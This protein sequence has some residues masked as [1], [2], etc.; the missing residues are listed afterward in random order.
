[1]TLR[2]GIDYTAAAWQGAGIG[3]YTRELVRAIVAQGGPY[4]YTLF[5]AA[6]GIDRASPYL[7]EL[8]DLCVAHPHVRAVPIPLSPR[9]LT[10]I[11]Q[12]LRLPL[13]VELF[14]GRIDL[15][16][17][18]DFV[19]PPTRARTILTIHDLSFL[20][21][22]QFAAQGMY[23]YLSTAVPRS[24]RRADAVVS[25]S[26]ATTR[27]LERLLRIDPARVTLV[28]PGVS[29][30]FRPL[31]EGEIELVRRRLG[32]PASFILFVSTLEPRKNVARLVEAFARLGD[33]G[34]RRVAGLQL[35]I[36][37]RRGWLYQDIFAAI[38]R[39]GVGDRVHVLDFVHDNDLPALYNLAEVFAYP[40]IYEGFGLPALEALACGTPVLTADNSSL[41]EVV[42]D[43]ALLVPAE[44]VG[45]IAG[46]LAQLVA[47]AALRDR[48]RAAGPP[49]A[50]QYTWDAAARQVLAC[51]RRLAPA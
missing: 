4:A 38:E 32:L 8:H 45:A 24:L 5:Y 51:Y 23:R 7:A 15:L 6:G 43:A 46:G 36:A 16:H 30:R 40:S 35:V 47:D 25:D 21:Y 28:Y 10:Q 33:S 42:G 11:W 34:D 3:R 20:I 18:P 12:R 9:R 49:R 14:T 27:D 37:G 31:P 1:M 2:I 17:A 13:P 48:L 22:P 44:D 19:L 39:M 50:R 29:P 26:E 41:P